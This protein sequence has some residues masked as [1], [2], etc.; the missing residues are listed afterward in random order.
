M[1]KLRYENAFKTLL[2]IEKID[3]WHDSFTEENSLKFWK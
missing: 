1:L 2:I 3:Y